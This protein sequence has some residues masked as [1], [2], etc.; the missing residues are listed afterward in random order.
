MT[1]FVIDASALVEW[2]LRTPCGERVAKAVADNEPLCAPELI[3]VE[4][5]SALHRLVRAGSMEN[6]RADEAVRDLH[7]APIRTLPH[8]TLIAPA[9]GR[10]ASLRIADAFYLACAHT[11]R[12]PLLT[13]DARLARAPA[14]GIT[15]TLVR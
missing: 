12:R 5:L 2:L 13:S 8:R 6:G 10:R 1:G 9:W 7:D 11:T 15:V 14:A 3:L 4:T